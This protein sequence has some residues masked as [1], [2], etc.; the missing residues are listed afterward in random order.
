MLEP[1]GLG[2]WSSR[3][4]LGLLLGKL[5]RDQPHVTQALAL[6]PPQNLIKP[7][8]TDLTRHQHLSKASCAR[9]AQLSRTNKLQDASLQHNE[10]N[11][12]HHFSVEKTSQSVTSQ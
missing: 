11:K 6:H 12:V 3:T 2:C 5:A 9:D 7:L 4:S 10:Q 1:L 8:T